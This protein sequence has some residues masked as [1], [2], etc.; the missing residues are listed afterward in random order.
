MTENETNQ[1]AETPM[2]DHVARFW[3]HLETETVRIV[4]D[5]KRTVG[6]AAP[7]GPLVYWDMATFSDDVAKALVAE[8]AALSQPSGSGDIHHVALTAEQSRESLSSTA[9]LQAE[10]H[11]RDHERRDPF[12]WGRDYGKDILTDTNMLAHASGTNCLVRDALQRAYKEIV[13]GR[14]AVE[15]RPS[16]GTPQ[17]EHRGSPEAQSARD[18]GLEEAAK[19]AIEMQA[20]WRAHSHQD[21]ASRLAT[22]ML[23]KCAAAI[24]ARKSTPPKGSGETDA[25]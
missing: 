22:E 20:E 23:G 10:L 24:L 16:S 21:E 17:Q 8:R 18:A 4:I 1:C 19:V 14:K 15:E 13:R 25:A 9:A 5:L 2:C 6:A 11:R 7:D 3:K 12:M